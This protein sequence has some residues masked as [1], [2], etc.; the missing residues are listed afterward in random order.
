MTRLSM[1]MLVLTALAG[2]APSASQT[3]TFSVKTEEVRINVLVTEKGKPVRGLTA[4]DFEVRDTGVKQTINYVSLEQNHISATLV[5]DMSSSV[6]GALL[7]NLKDAGNGLLDR[8]KKGD[9]AA[10]ITFDRAV[11]LGSESTPD[12]GRVKTALDQVRIQSPQGGTTSLIDASFAGLINAESKTDLPLV[13]I[14]T[15][16]L[17]TSSWLTHEDVMET[18][19]RCDAVVYAVSAGRLPGRTF[20]RDLTAATGGTAFEVE[21]M[22]D[23]GRVFTN[24]IEEFRVRYLLT[25]SP[26][27]V[28]KRGWHPLAV[29]VKRGNV[30]I[31][32]RTGYSSR[33]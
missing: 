26:R 3:P 27:G 8:L 25:Y 11:R 4:A 18:A 10:L 28:S 30:K 7:Q 15:D 19:K 31:M 13:V 14:F 2:V 16:G 6:A 21:S 9:R 20:L 33:D 1:M 5:F 12:I 22:N 32:A 17:D 23:I 29:R 24:I